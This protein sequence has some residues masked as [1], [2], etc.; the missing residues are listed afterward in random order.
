MLPDIKETVY[1]RLVSPQVEYDSSVW[2]RNK[3]KLR[4]TPLKWFN[5]TNSFLSMPDKFGARLPINDACDRH[6][7]KY[8]EKYLNTNTNTF[9]KIKYKYKYKYS[10][11]QMYLNT[12]TNTF[13]SISNTNTNTFMFL[14]HFS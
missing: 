13:K 4:Y 3:P 12:N 10:Q 1:L 11:M 6:V 5:G 9:H 8:I 7:V 2:D 14:Y